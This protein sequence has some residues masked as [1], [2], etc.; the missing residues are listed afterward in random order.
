MEVL[1]TAQGKEAELLRRVVLG[2]ISYGLGLVGEVVERP[3]DVDRIMGFGFNW[4]PPSVLVDAIGAPRVI[5]LL[6]QELLPIP[7]VVVEAAALGKPLFELAQV[8]SGK[9]FAAA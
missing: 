3:R 1:C 9:F 6:A 5:D 2:Y 8:D 7:G 4:A